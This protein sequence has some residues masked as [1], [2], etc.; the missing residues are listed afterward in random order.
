MTVASG[1]RSDA[2]VLAGT[3][4][5]LGA[6][7]SRWM[8]LVILLGQGL[9]AMDTAIVN[10]AAPTL[11]ADLGLSGAGLQLTVAGYGLAYASFLITASRLGAMFGYR[12]LFVIGM[13]V[14]TFSSFLCGSADSSQTLILGRIL[15]GLGAAL[16]VPQVLSLIQLSFS[17]AQRARAVGLYSMILGLGAAAGQLLGGVVVSIDLLGLSWR[18]AFLI[19]IPLG[20]FLVFVALIVLPRSEPASRQ[21]LDIA[22]M[23]AIVT[24]AGCILLA[25]TFGP[26][27]GWPVW[28]IAAL[29]V[30]MVILPVFWKYEK[31]LEARG[32]APV[33]QP[34]MLKIPGILPGLGIVALGFVGYGGWLLTVALYLQAGIQMSPLQ[35]GLTF[36]AYAL[37]FG[38]SN[39]FWSRLPQR[40]IGL[41][42]MLALCALS[43]A[44][45]L[46]AALVTLA[47]WH[48]VLGPSLLFVAGSGHGMSFGATV[49][50][51]ANAIPA[52]Y[53]S[54][55]S[56]LVTTCSQFSIVSGTA[57]IGSIYFA[58]VSYGFSAGQPDENA[59]ACVA[60]VIF[61]LASA[62]I[63]L[64]R[65]LPDI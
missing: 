25:V 12:R 57:L 40:L 64:S 18:P 65:R 36:G 11:Q 53:A 49:S 6:G 44:S 3:P 37:G 46:I 43:L 47:S 48:S 34:Q 19:N 28:A 22:G 35:S 1:N 31:R 42:P 10:V 33:L 17:G 7:R 24:A 51:M 14:F 45:I 32:A 55:L 21:R 4:S 26:E 16:L 61:I 15:Q 41:A 59:M 58:A 38:L 2:A 63:V 5:D 8:L 60:V 50:R 20:V 13:A 23:I 52:R 56:G 54:S 30:G 39:L 9:A 29:V 27:L 62:G